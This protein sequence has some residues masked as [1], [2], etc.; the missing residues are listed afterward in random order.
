MEI[1]EIFESFEKVHSYSFA[2]INNDFLEIRIAHFLTY[3][4]EGIY[5]QT[6][7]VKPFYKELIENKKVAVCSLVSETVPVTHDENGLSNFPPEFFIRVS[8]YVRELSFKEL[9][10]KALTDK[11]FDPLIKDI[12]RYPSMTTFVLHKFKGEVY[13]YDFAKEKSDHKLKRE[14]FSFGGMEYLEAGLV[15]NKEKCIACGKCEKVCS[16]GAIV[17]GEKYLINSKY[18]DECGSCAIVYPRNAINKPL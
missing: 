18:C 1:R 4:E 15:V 7:K 11:S 9:K 5:F 10:K 8:G 16:F 13:N 2:T 14:R 12:E 17:P 3:D 6:M